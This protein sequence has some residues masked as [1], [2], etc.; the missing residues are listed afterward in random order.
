MMERNSAVRRYLVAAVVLLTLAGGSVP[1]RDVVNLKNG[2]TLSGRIIGETATE[3]RLLIDDIEIPLNK[4]HIA[5]II[6]DGALHPVD[7]SGEEGSAGANPTPIRYNAPTPTP[8]EGGPATG[9]AGEEAPFPGE[10][11]LIPMLLPLD[12]FR[13]VTGSVV[14][15][16]SGP[17][18][19]SERVASL[20]RGAVLIELEQDDAWLHGRTEDG[21]KGWIATEYTRKANA[22][23]AVATGDRLNIRGGPGLD[24]QVTGQ[25]RRGQIV[26][27]IDQQDE[28]AHIRDLEGR[29]GWAAAGYLRT[30]RD[31]GAVRPAI[32]EMSTAAAESFLSE[33]FAANWSDGEG[34]WKH[35]GMTV[36]NDALVR[37]GVAV[38]L[39]LS[40][41]T[42]AGEA[43]PGESFRSSSVIWQQQFGSRPEL[44]DLGFSLG[45]VETTGRAAVGYVQGE[46]MEG[47][48]RIET[49]V[50]GEDLAVGRLGIVVQ[51]GLQRGAVAVFE[52]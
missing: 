45:L 18:T 41:Q 33:G 15:F 16:R 47:G 30:I 17:G 34:G 27:V 44:E 38:L 42:R 46:R 20:A 36:A 10:Q 39:L 19:T 22:T 24:K 31:L 5:S 11:P 50:N 14:N 25:L 51:E 35:L 21:V 52:H 6:R 32:A 4:E 1:A 7:S 2:K 23:V 37:N 28:W 40:D 29:F 3:V 49:E 8:G 12:R 13:L 43:K 9:V 48:W 26:M